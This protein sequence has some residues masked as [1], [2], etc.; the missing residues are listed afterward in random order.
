MLR[1]SIRRK[2]VRRVLAVFCAAGLLGFSSPVPVFS[3]NRLPFLEQCLDLTQERF[4]VTGPDGEGL[5]HSDDGTRF[6][7]ADVTPFAPMD[8]ETRDSTGPKGRAFAVGLGPPNRWDLVPAWIVVEVGEEVSLLQA[9]MLA[10]GR[11]LFMPDYSNEAC[12]GFL[13]AQE[14]TAQAGRSGLWGENGAGFLF[15]AQMPDLIETAAGDYGIV[16]GPIVSLGKTRSTRYL[17][18]G[19]YWKKDFTVTMDAAAET[20]LQDVL[21]RSGKRVETLA[22]QEVEVRGIIQIW[23]GPHIELRHPAQLFVLED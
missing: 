14:Q 21:G 6:F 12:A 7:P 15:A 16:H 20:A 23:D 4:A 2:N 22:G 1:R 19:N 17:N 11:A 10:E 13:R 9:D 18:F 8:R 3:Q 5:Y